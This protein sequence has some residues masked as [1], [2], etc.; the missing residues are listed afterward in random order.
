VSADPSEPSQRLRFTPR[1]L[2]TAVALLGVTLLLMRVFVASG[3][4]IGWILAAAVVAGL[5]HP[6]VAGLARRMPRGVA[7]AVIAISTLSVV[8]VVTYGVIDELVSEARVIQE[9]APRAARRLERD[10]RFGEIAR[11]VDLAERTEEF[12]D[13]VPQLL[14][15]GSPE[16]ALR[17]AANRGVAF[18]A[19]GVLTLFFLGHGPRLAAAALEQIHDQEQRERVS[20]VAAGAYRRAWRYIAGTLLMAAEAGLVALFLARVADV[21]GAEVLALWTALWDIVPVVGAVL[22]SIPIVL[23]A[24]VDSPMT[25]LALAILLV[26]YEVFETLVLQRRVEQTSLHL[27][28][29]LTVIA[30]LIGLEA[31]GLGGALLA[32]VIATCVVAVAEELE[33]DRPDIPDIESLE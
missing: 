29:F 17:S 20:R 23:L 11:D 27:G 5:L 33:A 19:T 2:I 31:Y 9:E 28:P 15:G 24:A 13:D 7:V 1:S 12:V 4:V 21:P 6:L 25:A 18:L 22:G 26:G 14:R 30:G 16:D 10:D 3:R 8:T 32:V